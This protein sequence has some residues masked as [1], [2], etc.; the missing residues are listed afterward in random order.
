MMMPSPQ[1]N[2][3]VII[4]DRN[5]WIRDRIDNRWIHFF[6]ND[7]QDFIYENVWGQYQLIGCTSQ[8]VWVQSESNRQCASIRDAFSFVNF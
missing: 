4:R 3:Q 7:I 2:Q 5:A 8:S 6:R 1:S